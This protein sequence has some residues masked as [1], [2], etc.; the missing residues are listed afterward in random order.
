M[1]GSI[2]T[3]IREVQMQFYFY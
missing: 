3:E 1:R 2:Q